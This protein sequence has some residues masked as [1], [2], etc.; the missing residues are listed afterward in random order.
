MKWARG[1]PSPAPTPVANLKFTAA[2]ELP[3][4]S[5]LSTRVVP[6]RQP[7]AGQSD[8]ASTAVL[9]RDFIDKKWTSHA[10]STA[11]YSSHLRGP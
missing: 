10:W 9:I 3:L 2:D 6:R 11:S 5:Q 4:P 7:A 1:G 8:N